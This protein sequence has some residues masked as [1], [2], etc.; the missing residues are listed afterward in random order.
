MRKMIRWAIEVKEDGAVELTFFCD[1]ATLG[2][3][4][5]SDEARFMAS[6]ILAPHQRASESE[7]L[8]LA[9]LFFVDV[10]ALQR[11]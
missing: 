3:T 9:E 1:M 2:V 8:D 5:T 6:T 7:T 11:S 4:L 10:A